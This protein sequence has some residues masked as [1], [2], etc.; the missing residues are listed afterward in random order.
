VRPTTRVGADVFYSLRMV[1]ESYMTLGRTGRAWIDIQVWAMRRLERRQ[2]GAGHLAT[3]ERGEWEALFHLRKRGYIVVARRWKSAKLRGDVDLIGWDG[4]Q[5]CFIEVKTRSGRDAMTAESAVD[6][7]KQDMLRRMARA[8]MRGFP[9]RPRAGVPTRFDV[10]SVYL[11]PSGVEFELYR[12][13]F[14]W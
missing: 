3:G 5:L 12:G 10:V 2:Q 13:A 6:G 14:G 11:L 9:E 7:D 4:D 1:G 8:Y